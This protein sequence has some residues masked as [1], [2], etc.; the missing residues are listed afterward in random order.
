MLSARSS[1]TS[2]A[3]TA[4]L[5]KVTFQGDTKRVKL[6]HGTFEELMERTRASFSDMPA[7]KNLKFFYVDEENDMISVS[8]Q[9]DLEEGL[10]ST[11]TL[12]LTVAETPR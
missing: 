12:R 11:E 6:H 4:S 5:T 9:A 7:A 3:S 2:M 8:S 10:R 1:T